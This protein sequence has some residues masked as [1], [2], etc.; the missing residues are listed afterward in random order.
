MRTSTVAASALVAILIAGVATVALANTHNNNLPNNGPDD[1]DDEGNH[2]GPIAC[3]SLNVTETLT[4][5][6]LTGHY[7]NA[8]NHEIHGNASGS[9]DLQVSQIYATGCT[10][11]ITG[12]TLALGPN[13]YNITGGSFVLNHGGRAGLGSGT[14]A[15]G[16]FLIRIAGLQGNSTLAG[17]GAVKL[18]LKSGSSEFLLLLGSP[19]SGED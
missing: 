18:D 19:E 9:L 11:T 1:H 12:G 3:R 7:L 5:S 4:L 2:F 13:S 6:N 16:S 14:I 10:L 17:E 15:G 8:T